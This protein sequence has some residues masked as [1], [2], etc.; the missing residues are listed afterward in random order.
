M[1]SVAR[2]VTFSQT[3]INNVD[4]VLSCFSSSRHKIVRLDVSVYDSLFV[5]YLNS[6]EHLNSDVKNRGEV[7]FSS[8]LLEKIF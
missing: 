4:G 3:E 7:K 8:A 1:L 2:L 5:D 6:L